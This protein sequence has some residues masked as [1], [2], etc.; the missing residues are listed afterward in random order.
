MMVVVA[1]VTV[2]VMAV[3][4]AVSIVECTRLSILSVPITD[5]FLVLPDNRQIAV[6]NS[7][8]EKIS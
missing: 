2:A 1:V 6:T 5:S 4:G 7:N 8:N 3:A